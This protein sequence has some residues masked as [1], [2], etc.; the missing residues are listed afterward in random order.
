MVWYVL[1]QIYKICDENTKMEHPSNNEPFADEQMEK[2]WQE[3]LPGL[4]I[5]IQKEIVFDKRVLVHLELLNKAQKE[6]KGTNN[7]C[8][9]SG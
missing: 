8:S 7:L 4:R 6:Q 3:A 9:K 5:T 1:S 2:E